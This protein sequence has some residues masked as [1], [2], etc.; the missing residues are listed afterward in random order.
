M[1]NKKAPWESE[2]NSFFIEPSKK[3]LKN[4]EAY[5]TRKLLELE[6]NPFVSKKLIIKT[7][8]F[9]NNLAS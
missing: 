9:I 2:K 5:Q 6:L 1:P 7:A 4:S 3:T 8:H